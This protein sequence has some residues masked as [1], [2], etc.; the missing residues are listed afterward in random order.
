[1]PFG[2]KWLWKCCSQPLWMAA[3][4]HFEPQAVRPVVKYVHYLSPEE[5][6]RAAPQ[7]SSFDPRVM[8]L[9]DE[10]TS[11]FCQLLTPAI[12][13]SWISEVNEV[14]RWKKF[15]FWLEFKPEFSMSWCLMLANL[16]GVLLCFV[17]QH[18]ADLGLLWLSVVW[19]WLVGAGSSWLLPSWQ[20]TE[21]YRLEQPWNLILYWGV[22]YGKLCLD[23]WRLS[24]ERLLS[25]RK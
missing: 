16:D 18:Q 20:Q 8:P 4:R 3:S 17:N 14:L 24:L 21:S 6:C 22:R 19:R 9:S 1:M 25:N 13:W 7:G 2:S 23:L 12:L 15:F 10:V 11:C 5:K